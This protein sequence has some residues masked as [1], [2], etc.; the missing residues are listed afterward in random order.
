MEVATQN[1]SF[2]ISRLMVW[3]KAF[4]Q[5]LHTLKLYS[6]YVMYCA[7]GVLGA[8]HNIRRGM[9]LY[10]KL[11]VMAGIHTSWI[12]RFYYIFAFAASS[13]Y[14]RIYI[15]IYIYIIYINCIIFFL[16]YILSSSCSN[17]NRR[18]I[19]GH[20]LHKN[21]QQLQ[22]QFC[23]CTMSLYHIVYSLISYIQ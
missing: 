2:G 4:M 23:C 12:V 16:I 7:C 10:I 8:V 1:V 18:L 20:F 6:L 21:I 22:S 19:V 3:L 13:T 15:Y 11:M 9:L 5:L 14:I 17:D